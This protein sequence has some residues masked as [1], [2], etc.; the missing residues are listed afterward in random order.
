MICPIQVEGIKE[1]DY[2][3]GDM[4]ITSLWRF[5]SNVLA[6]QVVNPEYENEDMMM[7]PVRRL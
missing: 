1:Y 3:M 4:P 7:G 6:N 5:F 2:S